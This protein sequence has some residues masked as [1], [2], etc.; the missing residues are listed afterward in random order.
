[1]TCNIHTTNVFDKKFPIMAMK[2]IDVYFL[3]IWKY[4]TC[5]H[6]KVFPYTNQFNYEKSGAKVYNDGVQP[7]IYTFLSFSSMSRE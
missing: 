5:L 7:K 2:I 1:M 3:R 4:F 6:R